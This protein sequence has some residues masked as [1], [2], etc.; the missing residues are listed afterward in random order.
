MFVVWGVVLVLGLAT[1]KRDPAAQA[2][3]DPRTGSLHGMSV[4]L[5]LDPLVRQ[6]V[7]TPLPDI[8]NISLSPW[9]YRESS[10][11]SRV[12]RVLSNAHCLT[13]GCLSHPGGEEDAALRVKPIKYQVLVLHRVPSQR[14]NNNSRKKKRRRRNKYE[15]RLETEVI[16]VGCTC[17]RSIV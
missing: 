16:T 9:T 3:V 4:R 6:M 8:A 13:S 5:V 14:Q 15:F 1:G 7:T 2:N 11:A 10:V 17:V 12:P